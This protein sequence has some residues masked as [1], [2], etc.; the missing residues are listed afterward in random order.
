VKDCPKLT[1]RINPKC[2]AGSMLMHLTPSSSAY[3]ENVWAWVADHDFDSGPA[4]TQ[5]DIYVARGMF[6]YTDAV[7]SCLMLTE[8]RYLD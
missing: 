3:L 4:Q 5:I 1:G 6:E 8:V 7:V 2:I